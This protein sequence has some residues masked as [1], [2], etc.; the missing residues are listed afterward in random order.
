M[1][2][3][4]LP[5]VTEEVWSWWREGS[6]HRA[7]WPTVE[8]I[9]DAADDDATLRAASHV[10]GQIRR[11]KTEAKVGMRAAV[12]RAAVSDSD[13]VIARLT[14]AADDLTRAGSIASLNLI[15]GDPSI[16]VELA[17]SE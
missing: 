6:I 11:T 7:A 9:T 4:F 2:A 3:P 1:L 5:F 14:A 13:E 8:E 10:L 12:A 17:A 15:V 16:E